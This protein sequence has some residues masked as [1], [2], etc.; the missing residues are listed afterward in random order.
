MTPRTRR[1]IVVFTH[2]F[3]LQGVDR[4][5]PAG[6]YQIVTD[7]ELLEGLSFAAYRRVSTMI[8]VPAHSH[9]VSSIEMVNI[10]PLDL[11][12][13][14]QRDAALQE[15]SATVIGTPVLA[16]SNRGPP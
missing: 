8:L 6:A 7:E 11:E 14:Q 13:A 4:V 16:A 1:D 15:S 9:Q 5:L 2:P 10:D 12:A 3:L